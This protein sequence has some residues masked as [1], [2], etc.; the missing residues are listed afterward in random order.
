MMCFGS[1]LTPEQL[2]QFWWGPI[3]SFPGIDPEDDV[4]LVP[5]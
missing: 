4:F 1:L 2:N 3:S 5:K